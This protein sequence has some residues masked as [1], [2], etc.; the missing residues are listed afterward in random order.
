MVPAPPTVDVARAAVR[1]ALRAAT[2]GLAP[3]LRSVV[4]YHFGWLDQHGN[5]AEGSPGKALRPTLALLSARAAGADERA[6]MPAAVA[7]ELVHNSSLLH[8]DLIDEDA[9][10]HHRPTVWS[11]FGMSAAVLA[12]DALLNLAY[13]QLADGTP[14]SPAATARLAAAT[15]RMLAGQAADVAFEE[16]LDVTVEECVTMANDKTAALLSGAAAVGSAYA[17]GP[18]EVTDALAAYGRHLG[19]AFQL[20]DDLL[21]IWGATEST[22]KPVLADLRA[23]K[24]SLPVVYALNAGG[25]VAGEL[26]DLYARPDLD[27]PALARCAELV[28]A[29]G[30]R[31]WAEREAAA[32]LDAAL[33]A[34]DAAALPDDVRPELHAVARYVTA[35]NR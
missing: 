20:V 34:L 12:G 21:G 23:R 15:G 7:V 11:V 19:L 26:A 16:R 3:W 13:E 28:V 22:G 33:Q 10:R 8:D 30:G 2:D 32:A 29:G 25:D 4:G 31:D 1:P 35:R 6:A 9:T 5:P 27:E 18:D 24:K 14:G 17:G